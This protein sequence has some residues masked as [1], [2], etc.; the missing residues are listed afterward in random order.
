MTPNTGLYSSSF[1]RWK[2]VIV[3][4]IAL[5]IFVFDMVVTTMSLPSIAA[6]LSITL[7]SVAWV[8]IISSLTMCALMLPLGR[9]ADVYGRKK[10]HM[11]CQK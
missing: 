7:R 11:N 2:I 1:S 3:A 5:F 9:V 4:A 6:D 8:V 10:L